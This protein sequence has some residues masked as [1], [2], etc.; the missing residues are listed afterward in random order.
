M[1]KAHFA[2]QEAVTLL[3]LGFGFMLW[4]ASHGHAD[5]PKE[6]EIPPIEFE[7]PEVDTLEFDCGL[8]GY[9]IEDRTIPLINMIVMYRTGF[10]PE[11]KVGLD[12][13][14]GWAIRNGGSLNY[15]KDVIDDELEFVGASIESN[16]GNQTGEIR[17]SFLTKDTELVL[18]ILA[19]IILNPAFDA[20]KIE[21]QKQNTI[22]AIRRKADD[23]KALGGR[24]FAKI[25]YGDHPLAWEP[26]PT[27]VSN[28]TRED[29]VGF[30]RRY[31]RPDNAV[32]GIT[33]DIT[34]REALEHLNRLF[35]DWEAGGE[36]PVFPEMPY[37]IAGS[38]NYIYKDVNQAYIWAGHMAMNSHNE[39][40]PI[41]EIM[42]YI[43]GGGA[44]ASWI[45]QRVRTDE[46]LAYSAGSRFRGQPWGYGLFTAS[47]QTRSDAAMRALG[48][49]TELIEKMKEAG[50]SEEEVEEAKRSMIN[51]Q[52]FD[53]ESS[54]R[55][56][57]RLV[58]Y[59]IVGLPLDTL[60]REFETLK[61]AT[62][63]DV[64]R[65]ADEYLHPDGLIV[66][67]IGNKDLFDRP[68]SDLGNVN[69]IEIEEE[70][71]Q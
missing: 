16:A 71:E 23:P 20:D 48:L 65:V 32:I 54:D 42:N 37:R 52:V 44:F 21:L 51:S 18:D 12:E 46:G 33:G 62:L 5:L 24:E 11:D 40:L 68:L 27:T 9:L 14:T 55:I 1:K 17:A 36:K 31:L 29:L 10:P 8:R 47:C 7:I 43:L 38:V 35:R 66:L 58:W 60:E 26:T 64:G 41:A 39:D 15:S 19:D 69:V 25:V 2:W 61:A 4:P 22:E 56:V 53:Y 50:P 45:T 28:I 3:F 6:L 59:D 34:P 49:M 30:H 13:I 70:M 57:R 67:V 63:A